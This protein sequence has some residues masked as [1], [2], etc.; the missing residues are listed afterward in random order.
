[1]TLLCTGTETRSDTIRK[2]WETESIQTDLTHLYFQPQLE[3]N[4]K[5]IKYEI[6]AGTVYSHRKAKTDLS[7]T[8]TFGLKSGIA[9]GV[10]LLRKR[11]DQKQIGF[12]RLFHFHGTIQV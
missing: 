1:M 6:C 5:L 10:D 4:N 9:L 12:E 7:L 8:V 3:T 11:F 2:S